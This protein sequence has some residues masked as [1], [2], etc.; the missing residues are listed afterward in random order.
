MKIFHS[1]ELNEIFVCY[2]KTAPGKKKKENLWDGPR[3]HLDSY[4]DGISIHSE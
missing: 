2:N 1:V 3:G 4:R